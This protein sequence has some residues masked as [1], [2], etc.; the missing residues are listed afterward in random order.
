MRL[1]WGQSD[2]GVG[3]GVCPSGPYSYGYGYLQDF[4]TV[5]LAS[6]TNSAIYVQDSWQP[7]ARLTLNLG[8][9]MEKEDVPS[10]SEMA[11]R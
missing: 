7:T 4:G 9:R 11:R 10:F 8:L 1:F 5:G 3:P 6:S 2:R